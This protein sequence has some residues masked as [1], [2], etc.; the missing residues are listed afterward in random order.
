MT[1]ATFV[2]IGQGLETQGE[3]GRK[4][5]GVL[6]RPWTDQTLP[7]AAGPSRY[8]HSPLQLPDVAWSTQESCGPEWQAGVGLQVYLFEEMPK[9]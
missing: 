6:A 7:S 8:P 5:S 3:V 2:L 9:V 1:L 4:L